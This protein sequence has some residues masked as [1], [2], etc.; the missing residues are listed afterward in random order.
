MGNKFPFIAVAP[1]GA[2][3]KFPILVNELYGQ[4][5]QLQHEQ[6]GM[7][8]GK[9]SQIAHHLGFIQREQRDAVPYLLQVADSLIAHRLGGGVA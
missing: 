5:V 6:S 9:R 7:V 3:H 4:A 8:F 1:G 2:F